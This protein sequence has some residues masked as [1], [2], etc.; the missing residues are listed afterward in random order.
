VPRLSYQFLSHANDRRIVNVR[1]QRCLG[2]L[3]LLSKNLLS[4][5]RRY[6]TETIS[7]T[8]MTETAK[9]EAEARIASTRSLPFSLIIRLQ[10]TVS[11]PIACI[12][13]E[14]MVQKDFVPHR[15]FVNPA[16]SHLCSSV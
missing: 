7:G 13:A 8:Q 1:K 10:R 2:V 4:R 9:P 3:V 15:K 12:F 14:G 6:R 16:T 5:R 11:C